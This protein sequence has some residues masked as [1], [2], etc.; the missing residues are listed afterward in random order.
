MRT[1]LTAVL[2]VALTPALHACCCGDDC[3]P[4]NIKFANL[5]REFIQRG[6]YLVFMREHRQ[7]VD[8]KTGKIFDLGKPEGRW[9]DI[10]VADGQALILKKDRLEAVNLANNKTIHDIPVGKERVYS[11]GFVGKDRAFVHQGRTLAIVDLAARKTLH[12]IDLGSDDMRWRSNAWQKVGQRLFVAGPDTTVCVIDLQTAK[13]ADR[14][15][16]NAGAGIASIHVEGSLVYCVGSPFSWVP[17]HS[18]VCYDMEMKKPFFSDLS[19]GDR[20]FGRVAGAPYGTAY[21]FSGN[22]IER[23]TMMGE[24]CGTFSVGEKE[25]VLAVWRGRAVVAGADEIRL[26]EIKETPVARTT[27]AR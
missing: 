3:F 22:K 11:L 14:F 8:L 6:D 19:R 17:N 25:T 9:F 12:T 26:V 13:L 23:L 10:D 15:H 20:F 4:T 18:L 16:I 24:R 27:S 1:L 21:L 2:L 5:P 7:V